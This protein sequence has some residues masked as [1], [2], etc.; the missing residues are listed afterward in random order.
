M[1]GTVAIATR[2]PLAARAALAVAVL[3]ATL[4]ACAGGS[5]ATEPLPPPPST[6]SLPPT[7]VP[8]DRSGVALPVVEAGR[9][10]TT[11][12]LMGPGTAIIRGRVVAPDGSPVEGANVRVERLVGDAV[13][14]TD[15]IAVADGAWGIPNVLG[16]RYRVR[17]WRAPDLALAEPLFLFLEAKQEGAIELKLER[18]LGTTPLP[19]VAPLKPVVGAPTNLV[20]QLTNRSVDSAGLIQ[21]TPI[22]GVTVELAGGGGWTVL[23]PNPTVT[24]AGGRARWQL[25]CAAAGVQPMLLVVNSVEQFQLA[26][27]ACVDP[28]TPPPTTVGGTTTTKPGTPTT[29]RPPTTAA[30]TTTTTTRGGPPTSRPR[31]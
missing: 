30:T 4:A 8:V 23:P 27:P 7:T 31:P 14:T 9:T 13:V 25:V 26:L 1:C 12:L 6:S 15:L 21:G 3:T 24:D 19:S 2:P 10:T 28:P 22:A 29:T 5:T 20:V 16:G 11:A 18:H 17:A